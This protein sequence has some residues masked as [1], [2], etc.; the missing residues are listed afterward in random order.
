MTIKQIDD[1]KCVGCGVCVNSCSMD[2]LRLNQ[3][4]IEKEEITPCRSAC[5]AGVNM[6]GYIY[7][8]TEGKLEEAMNLIREALPLPAI[9]G[10]VCFHPCEKECARK[11]VD[12]AVNI[13]ALERYVADYWLQEKAKPARQIYS[14]KAAII[15]SGPAGLAAAYDLV[16]MGYPVTVFET[17]PVLGGMLRTGI[18]EYRLPGDILDA[19]IDYIKGTGV[20]FKTGVTF[21]KDLTLNGLRKNEYEAILFAIGA[22]ESRK[23]EIDGAQL[24]DVWWGLDFLREVKLK[25]K[26]R[27]KDRVVVIGGGN[28]AID[29]SLTALRLGAKD[30]QIVCLEGKEEMPAHE[31]AIKTAMD[32]GVAIRASWGPKRVVGNRKR[33]EG[34]EL[35]RCLSVFDN[36]RRFNP[37][38]DEKTTR[39]METDMV[40]FAIGENTDLS[41]LPGEMKTNN[42]HIMVDPVTLETNL[43]GVFAAGV[44]VTGPGSVVEAIASGKKAA[45]S[46]DRYL[47]GKD[48][49]AGREIE[50][51]VVEKPPRE[52]VE[53]RP[54]QAISLLPFD[55]RKRNFSEIKM[56]FDRDRAEQEERRCMACGSRAFIKYLEDCMTCYTCEKDCPEKAIFVSPEHVLPK[57]SSW[58]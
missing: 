22:Q 55:Q 28:V 17:E 9:T 3:F 45:V 58:G 8:L 42:N 12:E 18:P 40:I 34:I 24:P 33:M 14:R 44:A 56:G 7:L 11:E 35:V 1:S 53:K 39:F 29:A 5:P 26:I 4:V 23:I 57:V 13:N 50:A 49:K 48:L 32:E 10:H 15:G 20:D 30:I 25:R 2:V 51:K 36:S 41:V 31:E 47:R 38:F 21:G 6:R 43:R 19:Q 37:S 16:K 46:I 27:V 54:R 52:G